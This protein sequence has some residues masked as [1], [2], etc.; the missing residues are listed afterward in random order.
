MGFWPPTLQLVPYLSLTYTHTHTHTRMHAYIYTCT[1]TVYTH[2]P[3]THTHTRT[4]TQPELRGS[5]VL[6]ILS[7][8]LTE[9]KAESVR[10][11]VCRSLAVLVAFTDD[12]NKF[13]QVR[14]AYLSSHTHTCTHTHFT[15]THT[16]THTHTRTHSVGSYW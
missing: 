1:C 16:H 13:K 2:L 3:N 8:M 4:H 9:D 14:S 10:Q 6:S 7:Q 5:L 12:S 11:A 15:H